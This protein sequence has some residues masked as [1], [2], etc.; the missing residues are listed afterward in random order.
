MPV[1]LRR[2]R[3]EHIKLGAMGEPIKSKGTV[4]DYLLRRITDEAT[5][6]AIEE[7]M[8]TDAQFCDEVA[9]AEDGLINDY[10]RG[11]LSVADSESFAETLKTDPE[12]RR[13]TSFTQEIRNRALAAGA[14]RKVER[15]SFF[16]SIT[17][18]LRRPQYAAALVILIA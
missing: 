1:M 15:P 13:Q 8:F 9:L 10:V 16:A 5:L 17:T 3:E 18:L 14:A 7:R 4:R 11:K 2:R 6:E 12:R